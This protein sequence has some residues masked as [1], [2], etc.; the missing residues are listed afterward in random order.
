[1][2]P[3]IVFMYSGQGSQYYQM[4]R[5][6]FEQNNIFRSY[7]YE[8]DAKVRELIGVSVRSELYEINKK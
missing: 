8:L 1:M 3:S 4:G 2:N 6:L 7:M 5:A